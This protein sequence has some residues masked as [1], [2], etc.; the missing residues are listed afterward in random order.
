MVVIVICLWILDVL[1]VLKFFIKRCYLVLGSGFYLICLWS[2]ALYTNLFL[3]HIL[4]SWICIIL[5]IIRT[6]SFLILLLSFI[7]LIKLA[8]G[9]LC[10]I[11][12]LHRWIV[13]L[14]LWLESGFALSLLGLNLSSHLVI[15]IYFR[16]LYWRICW[17]FP[18]L[19]TNFFKTFWELVVDFVLWLDCADCLARFT[20]W[21][22]L[23]GKRD[24]FLSGGLFI[25]V[26]W[27]HCLS[28]NWLRRLL[29]LGLWAIDLCT[30]TDLVLWLVC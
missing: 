24:T 22:I 10:L 9:I 28:Q 11:I 20:S 2:S 13:L 26:K 25:F 23:L 30:I 16:V 4:L 21:E 1:L 7:V 3:L 29:L 18:A 14:L 17:G 12:I 19:E 5:I 6:F 8:L 15:L 27:V